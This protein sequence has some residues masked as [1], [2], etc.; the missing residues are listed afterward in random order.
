[1][2]SVASE[3]EG[4]DRFLLSSCDVITDESIVKVLKNNHDHGR[5]YI[6]ADKQLLFINPFPTYH[7][8]LEQLETW[9]WPIHRFTL[10]K[11]TMEE[12][13]DFP[14]ILRVAA[15][16]RNNILDMKQ[17]HSLL[18]RG[19]GGSG[20]T[21]NMKK[22]IQLL[23]AADYKYDNV[24]TVA[25]FEPLGSYFNP[26]NTPSESKVGK[27]IAAGLLIYDALGTAATERNKN[28]TRHVKHIRI[29]YNTDRMAISG[30][31]MGISMTD[32]LRF[33]P[34]ERGQNAP[35]VIYMLLIGM[36][37]KADEFRISSIQRDAYLS[38]M[39]LSAKSYD[40]LKE[41]HHLQNTL[42]QEKVIEERD[43]ENALKVIA[44]V[45]NLQT[46][47]L[48]GAEA[49]IISSNTKTYVTNAEAL[50]GLETG[51]L[52]ALI[53]KKA[54]DRLGKPAG[55]MT[56]NK[57]SESKALIDALCSNLY[58]KTIKF[59][60]EKCSQRS[61]QATSDAEYSSLLANIP[62]AN[63]LFVDL[64]GWQRVD[65][66]CFGL[67]QLVAHYTE[68][69]VHCTYLQHVF[70]D[71]MERYAR[72]EIEIGSVPYMDCTPHIELLEKPVTGIVSL[73]EEACQSA[74]GDDKTLVDKL[75]STHM[76]GKLVRA[77]GVKGK[78]TI[79]TVRH[80]FGEVFYD[81]EGFVAQ[82]KNVLTP[83][84]TTL[85]TASNIDFIAHQD[86]SEQVVNEETKRTA[87]PPPPSPK[88]RRDSA[89]ASPS[90]RISISRIKSSQQLK[91]QMVNNYV[92]AKTRESIRLLL[93]DVSAAHVKIVCSCV[94]PVSVLHRLAIDEGKN[95]SLYSIANKHFSIDYVSRQVQFLTINSVLLLGKSGYSYI[96]EY[97]DF[98]DRFRST[99]SF[100]VDG[101]PLANDSASASGEA[102]KLWTGS[103][104]ISMDSSD[105]DIKSMCK[106]LIQKCLRGLALRSGVDQGSL[107]K[108]VSNL[109][110]G[111]IH[112]GKTAIFI[113]ED[114]AIRLE[115]YSCT[116]HQEKARAAQLIQSVYRMRGAYCAFRAIIR[117]L[118]KLQSVARKII[119]KNEFLRM[120]FAVNKIKALMLMNR[121]KKRL[122]MMKAAVNLLK[123]KFVK[124][125]IFKIRYRRLIRASRSFQTIC[126]GFAL[127]A[128][129]MSTFRAVTVLQRS[130]KRFL[131]YRRQ[132]H[133]RNA[134]AVVV[135]KIVRGMVARLRAGEV[136]HV[137]LFRKEQRIANRVVT[138]IQARYR[139]KLTIARFRQIMAATLRLQRWAVVW[140][141]RRKYLCIQN[142][143]I[144]LQKFT[145]RIIA[146]NKVNSLRVTN[147]VNEEKSKMTTQYNH[148]LLSISHLDHHE[149]VLGF[150]FVQHAIVGH[151]K[152]T[153]LL[154]G[155]DVN[156][157]LSIAY[158]E[159]WLPQ[160][161]Q[162]CKD[163]QEIRKQSVVK[164][165]LGSQHT[166][167]L[168][169]ASNVYTMGLGD[170]GQ[171]GHNNRN[172]YAEPKLLDKL[173]AI[174]VPVETAT[175]TSSLSATSKR[176]KIGTSIASVM[177][178][179]A[180]V[181]NICCGKDHTLL[182]TGSG[183]VFSW[184]DNKRGQLG[185]SQ[186]ESSVVPRLVQGHGST[187]TVRYVKAIACGSYHS[188]CLAEPGIVY[189]WG[190]WE[191]IGRIA[192][193]RVDLAV[194]NKSN[195]YND[196]N[197]HN[198]YYMKNNRGGGVSI[199]GS[200]A[201]KRGSSIRRYRNGNVEEVNDGEKVTLETAAYFDERGNAFASSWC[202]DSCEPESLLP[203]FKQK[204]IQDICSGD[205]H[206]TIKCGSE[207][208]AWGLNAQGQ[209]G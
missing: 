189:T 69:K 24:Q 81:C 52:T 79:F 201:V 36:G 139:C 41:F 136:V 166:V 171:L 96:E 175:F 12:A 206:V 152:Y 145:R 95:P 56:E 137:L 130:G 165:A 18:F 162:F 176:Y 140:T 108:A 109:S 194:S 168:D 31:H 33:N 10:N 37:Q 55:A 153:R 128:A 43:W 143:A 192:R 203:F 8:K 23:V 147:M 26:L 67:S 122:Q 183:R 149:R 111:M 124:E 42:V 185:H 44:A 32:M 83:L 9:H 82:N 70:A 107:G 28:S 64:P 190:S 34:R 48:V 75:M 150:G 58:T 104:S 14:H 38:P 29:I 19:C 198:N 172:S 133:R 125:F 141:Q 84:A 68:E 87:T 106:I 5:F 47:S 71:E 116:V 27:A 49:A 102:V 72:E 103:T 90:S 163:H 112:Y 126:K 146:T 202:V 195:Y 196:S 85:M 15:T 161:V 158:P 80:S 40:Y 200:G 110:K 138:K 61:F 39:N 114:L 177:N 50:L 178:S 78:A 129:A 93:S 45:I 13:R 118:T 35:H 131:G 89:L 188:L 164:I 187:D 180:V 174:L 77:G 91:S 156:F 6:Q 207:L 16:L 86:A 155:Y 179:R 119:C 63:I 22:I 173:Q 121:N 186:F 157:D 53:L 113:K 62:E 142:L 11:S 59:L 4:M 20:K 132:L 3:S 205:N 159:G 123:R 101:L 73:M 97:Q 57:P 148:E 51:S 182:L 160:I 151:G 208:Y 105:F 92:C 127:R 115:N 74:R 167:I 99:L 88:P 204:R 60:L 54:D 100:Q 197:N 21:E 134:A 98:Y 2:T 17:S 170:S 1:M 76:K 120:K 144:T 25:S 65:A 209:L 7:G 181:N 193:E 66:S 117:G 154:Y 94:A 169:D 135:Q 30:A 199:V 191:C 46:V 184:G